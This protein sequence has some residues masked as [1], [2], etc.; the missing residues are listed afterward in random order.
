MVTPWGNSSGIN[1]A[2]DLA[3]GLKVASDFILPPV[4]SH[5][6]TAVAHPLRREPFRLFFPLGVL[7]SWAGVGHWLLHGLG[8]LPDFKPIFHAMTQIQ[9]FLICFAIGFLF[10]MIPR[11]T[12]TDPP[13]AV[14]LVC[15]AAGPVLTTIA[16]W[17]DLWSWAQA[18]WLL[19]VGTLL[20]FLIARLTAAQH[21]RRPPNS[22]VWLPISFL[23]G[24]GGSLLAG[25]G[26]ANGDWSLHH[27]GQTLVL[28]GM[29]VGLVMGV[30]G[31]AIP[32]MTRGEKP[33]DGNASRGDLLARGAHLLA[34]AVLIASFVI[35][36][37]GLP[38]SGY[39]LRGSV[40][41]LTLILGPELH[42]LPTRPGWVRRLV[43]TSAW[44]VPLGFF[45]AAV[46][47]EHP[48]AGLHVTFI[49][50]LAMLT[51]AVS[52]LVTLAHGGQ[53]ALTTGRPWVVPVIA[54][55][56]L[57]AIGARVA[58]EYDRDRYFEWMSVA[59]ACF[60]GATFAWTV[61][62]GPK[63]RRPLS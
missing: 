17:F 48:K 58:M 2:A 63:L 28:Q 60:L 6:S 13:S 59:A 33:A 53:E 57:L 42:R 54:A 49:G 26:A 23:M 10:T 25:Y 29:F 35:E 19:T 9:G 5:T 32:L 45:L 27:L 18:G 16:A 3:P 37:R 20:S 61:Y 40:V 22:F 44:L 15:G 24:L 51:L 12:E 36:A 8:V 56:C 55:G 38:G 21:R 34:A 31:L 62:L 1:A 47:T 30:G 50:G 7:L 41:L 43:W 52:A 39:V 4:L 11:R 46:F 14:H